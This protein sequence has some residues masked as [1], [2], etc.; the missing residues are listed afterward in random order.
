MES[1]TRKVLMHGFDE[2][3][4]FSFGNR[5]KSWAGKITALVLGALHVTGRIMSVVSVTNEE[6][7]E[8]TSRRG[9]P[10]S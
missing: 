5:A 2:F 6:L 8:K 3:A 7:R 1:D 4:F 10:P 9:R